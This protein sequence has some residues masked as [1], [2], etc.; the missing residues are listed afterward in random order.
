MLFEVCLE[1]TQFVDG[2]SPV[3]SMCCMHTF[4]FIQTFQGLFNRQTGIIECLCWF[5]SLFWKTRTGSYMFCDMFRFEIDVLRCVYQNQLCKVMSCWVPFYFKHTW[6]IYIY[7][8]I[9]VLV[10]DCFYVCYSSCHCSLLFS[11]FIVIVLVNMTSNNGLCVPLICQ[12]RCVAMGFGSH[13]HGVACGAVSAAEVAFF[14]CG[15]AAMEPL[16]FQRPLLKAFLLQQHRL[17]ERHNPWSRYRQV[18]LNGCLLCRY[19]MKWWR[20]WKNVCVLPGMT[21]YISPLPP[22]RL[23]HGAYCVSQVASRPGK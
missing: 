15:G 9:Y 22:C 13:M 3:C 21:F 5:P 23:F 19:E 6:Y 4:W 10:T 12:Y 16:C 7:I 8:Y 18:H 2:G 20:L 1:W 11:A 14:F 17:S